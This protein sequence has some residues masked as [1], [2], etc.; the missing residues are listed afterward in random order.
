MNEE[1]ISYELEYQRQKLD[2][3]QEKEIQKLYSSLREMRHDMKNHMA[4]MA[5]R[6]ERE[7]YGKLKGYLEEMRESVHSNSS[8]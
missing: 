6:V 3:E 5:Q 8:D 1:R 4:F 2:E 7:D